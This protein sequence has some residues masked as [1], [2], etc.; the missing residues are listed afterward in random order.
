MSLFAG[1]GAA[2]LTNGVGA[3][4][5][6]NHPWGVALD[7]NGS[8]YVADADNHAIR[9]IF[10]AT[11]AVSTL[12]G[13][14]SSGSSDGTG[15]NAQFNRPTGVAVDASGNVYVADSANM[16]IRKIVLATAVVSAF[17][18]SPGSPGASNGI[19]AAASFNF[20]VGVAIYRATLFVADANN[21]L[22]R[23]IDLATQTVSTLAGS[24]VGSSDGVGTN[25]GFSA[26]SGLAVDSKGNLYVADTS[27]HLIRQIVATTQ[28]VSTLAG[29][30]T[31]GFADGIGSNALFSSPRG[32]AMGANGTLFVV[33]QGNNRVRQIE[34]STL[35]VSPLAG[36]A[37]NASADGTGTNAAFA[38]PYGIASDIGGGAT[39]FVTEYAGH[40]VRMLLAVAPCT[41][42]GTYCAANASSASD[43]VQ[44]ALGH[45]CATPAVQVACD[46]GY[47]CNVTGLTA[48]SGGCSAGSYCPA[49]STSA[50]QLPCAIRSFC[51]AL[52]PNMTACPVSHYCPASGMSAPT[53]C[54]AGAYCNA[55]GLSAATGP[56]SDGYYCGAGSSTAT[57][58]SCT[59]GTYC[60][61]GSSNTTSCPMG[62]YCPAPAQANYTLSP[63]GSFCDTTGLSTFKPCTAGSFCA[64]SGLSA[65]TGN[66]SAGYYCPTGSNSSTQ[67]A[68]P[69]GTYSPAASASPT[70]CDIGAFCASTGMS[71]AT[72]CT[73]G[74]YCATSSLIQP[75]DTCDP[76]YFCVAGSST[77]TQH[78]CVNGSYC[79]R[80]SYEPTV[81]PAF[82]ICSSDGLANYTLCTAGYYCNLTGLSAASAACEAGTYCPTASTAAAACAAGS[83]CSNTSIQIACSSGEYCPAATT[84]AAMCTAGSF[85]VT[86]ASAMALCAQ[87]YY[88]PAGSTSAAQVACPVGAFHCA[89]GASAPVSIACSVGYESDLN[90]CIFARQVNV[91]SCFILMS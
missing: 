29:S 3:L 80:G 32:L 84:A 87:G 83:M 88:C 81:C 17:A 45:V 53:S 13:S 44:C 39:L 66:C 36:S 69:N 78:V 58:Y 7:T 76:G 77:A 20:P 1:S 4:A 2:A 10:L 85:C 22:I 59:I 47:F 89:A 14:G 30:T 11:G 5:A 16:M 86:P 90:F 38:T 91:S 34:L 43:A 49:A 51:P 48:A 26:P 74:S 61:I 71:V 28:I 24:S 31:P 25:A 73:R 72:L 40:R 54:D 70:P 42:A 18:G 62:A 82:G 37:S 12:A 75:N 52:S 15:T 55:T 68:S 60:P 63:I 27:N 33:D 57:E 41:V 23:Q 6:L 64:T 50:M 35:I 46:A 56:C 21:A 19:G 79:P 67:L 65:P 8:L 9:Q